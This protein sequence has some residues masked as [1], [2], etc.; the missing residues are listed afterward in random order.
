MGTIQSSS[1]AEH[2]GEIEDPRV[3]YLVEHKL[4]DLL[5][6][7][8][9]AVIG[10]ADNWVEVEQFGREKQTWFEGFL[11]LEQGIPSHDTIGRVFSLIDGVQFQ[12][13]FVNWMRSVYTATEG[14]VVP[15]DGKTLRRSHNKR[16][17]QKAI[18][19]VSAWA[20]HNRMILGQIKVAEKSNEITA[21]P[22]LLELLDLRGCI[23]T[24]DAM[25]CQKEIA[26]KIIDGGA[27]YVLALKGNQSGLLEDVQE[28]FVYAEELGFAD[29]DYY[30]Q[31]EKG[32]GRIEIRECWTISKPE[33]LAFLR[34]GTD[35]RSL[36]SIVLVKSER[37][38]QGQSSVECRYFISSLPSDAK[39]MLNA[40][41]RHWSIE[42]EAFWTLDVAFNEDQSRSR[43][44]NSAQNFAVL[45]HIALN[46]LKQETT[47]KCG[48]KA[49]R[50]K[51]GWGEDYLLKVLLG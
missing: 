50:K 37:R 16:A 27:D 24:I 41:R 35:W 49:K 43:T 46:L 17:G 28:L 15:I 47:A 22:A 39:R 45:R 5:M 33:F 29:C 19:M 9:C 14:E 21:I 11:D 18:H 51:A 8:I 38:N 31:V 30:K 1:L 32:H 48:I 42:N 20:S 25:G 36:Q 4:M 7:S 40:A 23:V 34:N 10:G 13:C 3:G 44:K 2:F 12:E 26:A 6:I